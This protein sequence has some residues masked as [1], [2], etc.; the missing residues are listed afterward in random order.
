MALPDKETTVEPQ[1]FL[2]QEHLITLVPRVA[3]AA[4]EALEAMLLPTQIMQHLHPLETAV[5]ALC[6]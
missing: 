4:L 1:I 5:L 2:F 6:G 3:A